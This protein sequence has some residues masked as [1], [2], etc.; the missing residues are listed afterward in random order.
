MDF[1]PGE[2]AQAMRA[3]LDAFLLRFVL[4]YNAAWHRQRRRPGRRRSWRT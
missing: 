3:Q 4:P 1:R 2:R